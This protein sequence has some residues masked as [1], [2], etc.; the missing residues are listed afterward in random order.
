MAM[1]AKG[2]AGMQASDLLSGVPVDFHQSVDRCL[3]IMQTLQR[4]A[5]LCRMSCAPWMLPLE[6]AGPAAAVSKKPGRSILPSMHKYLNAQYYL[7]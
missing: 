2:F 5:L 7:L 1:P 6:A 3:A 4:T